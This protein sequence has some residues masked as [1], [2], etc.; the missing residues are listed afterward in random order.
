MRKTK[1]F[2]LMAMT[3]GTLTLVI[4]GCGVDPTECECKEELNR[5]LEKT[6][7]SGQAQ[8]SDLSDQCDLL[9]PD[10]SYID[11]VCE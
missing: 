10:V 9:Y 11:A 1:N 7:S 5:L 4:E 3:L 2:L 6:I 8:T